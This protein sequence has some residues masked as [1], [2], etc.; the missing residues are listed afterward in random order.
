MESFIHLLLRLLCWAG[1]SNNGQMFRTYGTIMLC[2]SSVACALAMMLVQTAVQIILE[3]CLAASGR[4]S[5]R[6]C[7]GA[8]SPAV[9]SP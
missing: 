1:N 4:F 9:A 6:P 3:S 8:L 5:S 2:L 7:S